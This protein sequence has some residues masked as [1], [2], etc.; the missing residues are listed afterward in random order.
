MNNPETLEQLISER[1]LC[2]Q[3][4]IGAATASRMRYGGWGPRFVVLGPR[5]VAYRPS[6]I[7]EWLA[8]REV[9]QGVTHQI[10]AI[11]IAGDAVA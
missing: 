2:K 5:R 7:A 1:E 10:N 4:G 8:A 3:L 9:R 11:V 6:A